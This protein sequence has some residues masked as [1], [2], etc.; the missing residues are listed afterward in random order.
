M[1]TGVLTTE[2]TYA[3]LPAG[4][5]LLEN[6]DEVPAFIEEANAGAAG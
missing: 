6:Q 5:A 1:P 3:C 4:L 2:S